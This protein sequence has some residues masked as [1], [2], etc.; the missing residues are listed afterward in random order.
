MVNLLCTIPFRLPSFNEEVNTAKRHWSLYAKH[1]TKYESDV[2]YVLRLSKVRPLLPFPR[3]LFIWTRKT[4]RTDLDNTSFG[5]KYIF[6]A[7]VKE[8]IIGDDRVSH[9][10]DIRHRFYKSNIDGVFVCS[11]EKDTTDTEIDEFIL[12]NC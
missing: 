4:S 10:T 1:K 2:R 12:K 3:I 8:G 9:I 6:D 5:Q 7:M 11:L